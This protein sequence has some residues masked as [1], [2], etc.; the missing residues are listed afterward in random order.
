MVELPKRKMFFWLE[1][2]VIKCKEDGVG[3]RKEGALLAQSQN[4]FTR[5][6]C[7]VFLDLR[8]MVG[9]KP[10]RRARCLLK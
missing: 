4:H 7:P 5:K 9:R 10:G 1:T 3:E 6:R 2:D 8:C